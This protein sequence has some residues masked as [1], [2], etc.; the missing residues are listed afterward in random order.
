MLA[1]C[2][3]TSMG[4]PWG[5]GDLVV[6][7]NFPGAVTPLIA[8]CVEVEYSQKDCDTWDYRYTLQLWGESGTD[9]SGGD[10]E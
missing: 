5:A 1:L 3:D 2:K 8:R 4:F 6:M 7:F 9:E 10:D